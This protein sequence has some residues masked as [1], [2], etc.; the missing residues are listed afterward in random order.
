MKKKPE[1]TNT[2][3]GGVADWYDT[4]LET[5][6]DSYQEK[7]IAPNLLRLLSLKKGDMIL[8]L[9]CGQGFFSRKFLAEGATVLGVDISKELIEAAKKRGTGITYS[10]SPAHKLPFIKN[11]SIDAVT[12]ILAI[13][14]IENMQEVFHEVHR[15][16][17]TNGRLVLVMNHPT[18]RIPKV[19]S[20]GFDPSTGTQYRR[21]DEYLSSSRTKIVVHPGIKNSEETVSYHRSLQDF[22]KSLNKAGFCVTKLEEWI[23]HKKSGKGPRQKAEDKSRR[24]IPLFLALET[25]KL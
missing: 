6:T 25:R 14:N 4:H 11:A 3:W 9:A 19:S 10:V 24:E 5:D 2:S 17:K 21:I 1:K 12:I 23:S 22:F 16:L 18:F 13:Q 15:V 7:V 8:D 20:W